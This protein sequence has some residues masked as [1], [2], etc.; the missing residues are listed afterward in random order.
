[1]APIVTQFTTALSKTS[2]RRLKQG[3]RQRCAARENPGVFYLS[4][5]GSSP[6]PQILFENTS[7]EDCR[8]KQRKVF[9]RVDMYVLAFSFQRSSKD[10]H[11]V[12]K[13]QIPGK[14]VSVPHP[15]Q[16]STKGGVGHTPREEEP[17][18][19]RQG[20]VRLLLL[21]KCMEKRSD[22]K[23]ERESTMVCTEAEGIDRTDSQNTEKSV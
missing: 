14:N 5:E 21:H 19:K 9:F 13:R 18:F 23:N 2:G 12:M 22:A 10:L 17:A 15:T 11:I 4:E 1:M 3:L 16:K 6:P 20:A 7:L 8:G